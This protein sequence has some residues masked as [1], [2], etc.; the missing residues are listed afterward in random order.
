LN[1]GNWR[2]KQLISKKWIQMATQ[3]SP[4]QVNY[5]YMWWLNKKGTS[6]YWEGVPENVFYAAGF[7]GNFII[8]IPDQNVVVVTRWLEPSQVGIFMQKVVNALP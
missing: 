3:S 8:I 4:A 2:G 1:E 7:G 5:G 6:R